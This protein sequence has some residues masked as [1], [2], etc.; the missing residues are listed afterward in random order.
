ME[1]YGRGALC[2]QAYLVG[3][4]QRHILRMLQ[5]WVSVLPGLPSKG[6]RGYPIGLGDEGLTGSVE[7]WE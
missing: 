2:R 6:L 3:S 4:D 1:E 5:E 7:L